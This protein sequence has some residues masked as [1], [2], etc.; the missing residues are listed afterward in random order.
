MIQTTVQAL[1]LDAFHENYSC[2]RIYLFRDGKTVLY[3]GRSYNVLSRVQEHLGIKARYK[4]EI[5]TVGRLVHANIPN[6]NKWQ[7]EFYTVW[8]CEQ[9]PFRHWNQADEDEAEQMM[10]RKFKPC[11][12]IDHNLYPTPFPPHYNLPPSILPDGIVCSS[13]YRYAYC[14]SYK[15]YDWYTQQNEFYIITMYAG[16]PGECLKAAVTILKFKPQAFSA[17]SDIRS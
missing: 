12:N 1:L 15:A 6:S 8:D 16:S 17:V 3:V 5:T 11:I 14:V 13:G 10:I 9:S 4:E 2:H 7:V